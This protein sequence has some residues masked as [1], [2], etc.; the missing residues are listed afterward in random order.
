MPW[1]TSF[2]TAL[3]MTEAAYVEAKRRVRLNEGWVQYHGPSRGRGEV[4]AEKGVPVA[5][6]GL[7]IRN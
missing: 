6:L 4:V 7:P 2:S 5:I 1:P 3:A